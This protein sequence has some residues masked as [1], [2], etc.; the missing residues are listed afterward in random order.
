MVAQ[1]G[2]IVEINIAAEIWHIE[3][4]SLNVCLEYFPWHET[5][6]LEEASMVYVADEQFIWR[7]SAHSA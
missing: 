5:I 1:I 7:T 2:P 3:R 6:V 4:K